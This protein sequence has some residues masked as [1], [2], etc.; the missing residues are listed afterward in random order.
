MAQD[1]PQDEHQVPRTREDDQGNQKSIRGST[2]EAP[3]RPQIAQKSIKNWFRNRYKKWWKKR[4]PK[5]D[6][7]QKNDGKS[8]PKSMPKWSKIDA[9][10]IVKFRRWN[11]PKITSK[12][13]VDSKPSLSQTYVLPRQNV[14][15]WKLG[16]LQQ[17]PHACPKMH[18]K[19]CKNC[20]KI[21]PKTDTKPI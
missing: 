2:P 3:S 18:Q 5:T 19:T 8:D 14:H 1:T 10:S 9:K 7:Y 16:E 21:D 17:Q 4:W 13:N 15:P 20:W 11:Q 6:T 12:S